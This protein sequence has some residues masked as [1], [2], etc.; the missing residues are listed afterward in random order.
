MASEYDNGVRK[1]DNMTMV[2]AN[3][4]KDGLSANKSEIAETVV[5][6][7]E[8]VSRGPTLDPCLCQ[9]KLSTFKIWHKVE[10]LL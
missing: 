6:N 7:D 9:T 3:M 8:I 5:N 10:S 2:S 4:M 1:S